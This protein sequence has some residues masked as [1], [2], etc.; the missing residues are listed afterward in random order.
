LIALERRVR[1]RCQAFRV[2]GTRWLAR[3]FDEA[4]VGVDDEVEEGRVDS[5]RRREEVKAWRNWNAVDG[6]ARLSSE[7]VPVGC[8][9]GT[10]SDK[11][12]FASE[13]YSSSGRRTREKM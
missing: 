9:A 11:Y 6:C 13:T 2:R 7:S 1:K 4:E 10:K 5:R 12:R 3:G 8:W